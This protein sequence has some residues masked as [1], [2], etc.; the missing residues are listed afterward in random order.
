MVTEPMNLPKLNNRCNSTEEDYLY[1]DCYMYFSQILKSPL[2]HEI[3]RRSSE[4]IVSKPK[5]FVYGTNAVSS[6]ITNVPSGEV[7]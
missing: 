7:C 6:V 5:P 3:H 2:I 1:K 4:L